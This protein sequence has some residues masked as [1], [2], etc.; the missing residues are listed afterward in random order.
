[1]L[2]GHLPAGYF[3][4]KFIL[5]KNHLPLN[6]KWLGLGLIASILPDFDIAYAVLF[7]DSMASHRFFFTNY[8]A[9]YL[10]LLLLCLIGY[11]SKPKQWLK[12]GI[13]V[14]FSN[15]FLHL[16]IDTVFVGIMW[17]WPFYGKLI[18]I[19]NTNFTGGIRVMNYF[20]HLWWY[21]EILLWLLAIISIIISNRKGELK[22]N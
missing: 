17:F 8:P 22:N 18:G 21:L 2:I 15:I 16:L 10:G 7:T 1:M 14:V 20:H 5:K 3:L 12:Y 4:S 11:Y 9:F 19:Y 13:I 6:K